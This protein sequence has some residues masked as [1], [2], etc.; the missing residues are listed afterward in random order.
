MRDFN[1]DDM[2]F[3]DIDGRSHILKEMREYEPMSLSHQYTPGSEDTLDLIAVKNYGEGSESD[4]YRIFDFNRE[5]IVDNGFSIA[6]IK[7]LGIP[8]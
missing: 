4:A 8:E 6:R 2:T 1:V 5:E 3:V 7:S